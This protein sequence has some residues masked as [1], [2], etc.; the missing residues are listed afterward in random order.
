MPAEAR[1]TA[2]Y[3][4]PVKGLSPESLGHVTLG[5]GD[6]FPWD[7]AYA[8]E[9]GKRVF[10][11]ENPAY[12]PKRFFLELMLHE[13]LARLRTRFDEATRVLSIYRGDD[14][15]VTADL[16]QPEGRA[17]IEA[18]M[19]DYMGSRIK[20]A[21]RIVHA[22]GF[23]FS[24]V[25]AKCISIVNLASV[26]ALEQVTGRPVDPLRFRANVYV[27]GLEPWVDHDWSARSLTL[28]SAELEGVE[29]IVRCAAT[30]VDPATGARDMTIPATLLRSY[31]HSFLGLYARVRG[32]GSIR[33]GDRLALASPA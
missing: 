15:L 23:S 30:N 1:I 20:G 13:E 26:R 32:A 19:A 8:I 10:D 5:P 2:L 11:E 6:C 29:P 22:P 7:R 4:Y 33:P 27:E 17:A 18:F 14:E 24:D 9:Q 16:G 12:F 28:G 25:P 21:P 31:G 3:R